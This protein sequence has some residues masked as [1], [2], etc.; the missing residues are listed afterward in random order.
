MH[1]KKIKRII[2][3]YI[4]NERINICKYCNLL[5]HKN[6]VPDNILCKHDFIMCKKDNSNN[7]YL[8]DSYFLTWIMDN[9]KKI[10]IDNLLD[11][12]KIKK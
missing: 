6:I 1:N 5:T 8:I 7:I 4:Y 2:D 12:K 3:F 11:L 10:D 9:F